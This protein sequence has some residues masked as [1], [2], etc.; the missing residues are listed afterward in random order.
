LAAWAFVAL[1]LLA[2]AGWL[3]EFS[4]V[5]VV[6]SVK[7]VGAPPGQVSA[8]VKRAAIPMGTPLVKID[9]RAAGRRVLV[10]ETLAKVTV[11]RSYPNTILIVATTRVPVLAV[12]NSQG[13]VQV[14][15]SQGIAYATVKAAPKG[16]PLISSVESL[17]SLQSMRAALAV[18]GAL[19]PTQRAQV[20]NVTVQ[21]P[22][23]VTFKLG[24]VLV[25]WGDASEPELKVKV[26][27]DLLR[28]NNVATIDVSAP[29]TPVIR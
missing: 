8:I 21:G 10:L 14:V 19:S 28:Q 22:N 2:G 5:L 25:M 6:K 3:V 24:A 11:S 17:S 18:L 16:V 9:T 1:A 23:M 27:T 13:Q 20:T 26:M 12:R 29:W 7:V 4:P 15:D